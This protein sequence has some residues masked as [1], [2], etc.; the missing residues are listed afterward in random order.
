MRW[1]EIEEQGLG[2]S[3]REWSEAL[4]D[5][6]DLDRMTALGRKAYR[7]SLKAAG[8]P[9]DGLEDSLAAFAHIL[10][11]MLDEMDDELWL[12]LRWYLEMEW[13]VAHA[14]LYEAP[15]E[16]GPSALKAMPIETRMAY[17]GSILQARVRPLIPVLTWAMLVAD[18]RR[19]P[20]RAYTGLENDDSMLVAVSMLNQLIADGVPAFLDG[21]EAAGLWVFVRALRFNDATADEVLRAALH[22]AYEVHGKEAVLDLYLHSTQGTTVSSRELDDWIER[23]CHLSAALEGF[24]I[25]L[26]ASVT[27]ENGPLH[28]ELR[29]PKKERRRKVKKMPA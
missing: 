28:P 1:I 2:M 26:L 7:S 16:A 23:A 21:E 4:K 29:E 3:L 6:E 19:A 5:V 11:H 17:L 10:H 27:A 9:L 14:A 12:D 24:K 20:L 25:M 15:L 8:V 22:R 18:G 13:Q